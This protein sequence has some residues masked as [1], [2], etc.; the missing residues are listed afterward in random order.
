[1]YRA[2]SSG[3]Q[4]AGE[5]ALLPAAS[6]GWPTLGSPRSPWGLCGSGAAVRSEPTKEP[7]A[8]FDAVE[9]L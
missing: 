1:M 2:C 3:S 9:A 4:R 5:V 7:S 8:A 6:A